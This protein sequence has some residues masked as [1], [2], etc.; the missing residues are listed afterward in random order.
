MKISRRH[1]ADCV[2]KKIMIALKSVPHEHQDYFSSFN[3]SIGEGWPNPNSYI[4]LEANL[5]LGQVLVAKVEITFLEVIW[6][7]L[8][9]LKTT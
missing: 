5:I 3:Q 9:N 4:L 7:L 1:L 8:R 6:K 2:K